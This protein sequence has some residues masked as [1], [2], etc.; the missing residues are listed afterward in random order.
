MVAVACRLLGHR[1][2]FR[3]EGPLML[4]ECERGCG[5]SG[6]KRYDSADVAR[7]YA[8]AFDRDNGEA[9]GRR[10]TLST[11]PLALLRMLRGGIRR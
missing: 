7:R 2:R 3:A 9:I 5:A 11:V 6:R 10:P 4:W 8:Q 1:L